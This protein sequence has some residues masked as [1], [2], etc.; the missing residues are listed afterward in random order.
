LSPYEP[1]AVSVPDG[2]GRA[3]R[4]ADPDCGAAAYRPAGQDPSTPAP[5]WRILSAHKGALLLIALLSGAAAFA[6]SLAQTPMYRARALLEIESLNEDFLNMR[7]V[8]P[9]APEAGYASPE[10]NIRTQTTVLQSRPVLERTIDQM[11]LAERLLAKRRRSPLM[12][13][14]NQKPA[15][16]PPDAALSAARK[17]LKVRVEPNTRVIEVTFDAADP[18]LAADFVNALAAAFAEW[19]LEKRWETSQYTSKWLARELQDVKA[20]LETAEDALQ[21]YARASELTFI[22]EKD[23]AA[24]ERFRQLQL[25][26]SKA[27]A[28]RVAKQS[29]YELA[30]AAPPESLPEVLSDATLKAYQVDLTGLR[31]QLAELLSSFTAEHPKV[32]KV[33]SQIAALEAALQKERSNIVARV[34]NEY[35]AASRR[36]KLLRDDYAAQIALMS[37]QAEKV[38]HYLMLKREVDS[39]RQLHDSMLQKVKEAGVASAMRASNVRVIE[40]AAPPGVPYKPDFLVNTAF[41]LF[42]GMCLGVMLLIHRARSDRGIQEPGDTSFHLNVPELGVIPASGWDSSPVQRILGKSVLRPFSAAGS[43]RLELA[44]WQQWP[45]AIAECFRLTLTSILLSDRTRLHPR[46]IVVS[47]ANPGEG[48]TTVLSNLGIALARVDRRVLL[49]D[50]DMRKPRLHEVFDVENRIGFS[51]LLTGRTAPAIRETKIPNLF[52]LP[53]GRSADE[54]LLFTPQLGQLLL[55]FKAEFDMVLI[56]TP[57][58][59]QISDARLIAHHADAVILVVAQYSSRESVLAARQRLAEDGSR[60]LGT[61]LNNWN[62][63]TGSHRYHQYYSYNDDYWKDQAA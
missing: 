56:D 52:V 12:R 30:A 38:A 5:Y 59:L 22:S 35:E 4:P 26:L 23:N 2:Q 19:N 58:L 61:I 9:T 1:R 39:T 24:E 57:P 62:P 31:R 32:I 6:L 53:S 8:N 46:A 50:G 27:Q 63:R 37:Q 47:S 45:S 7:H 25:E 60:L 40:P 44:A 41:G 48:K 17:A 33:Q 42:S 34:R 54:R 16:P 21:R 51:D 3:L 28:D 14:E 10:Y 55:R 18:Q 36:E 15:A 20:K 11:H 13:P 29:G 49:V 43:G